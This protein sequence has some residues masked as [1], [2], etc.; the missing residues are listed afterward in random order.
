[1][2]ERKAPNGP[3]G[4]LAS[5]PPR[6][7][8][9]HARHH[10]P[11]AMLADRST[12]VKLDDVSLKLTLSDK[13]L[14]KPFDQAVLSPFLKAYAKRTG[15]KATLDQVS[16]V[17][18]DGVLLGDLS[19]AAS[20]VLL[21]TEAVDTDIFMRHPD[22]RAAPPQPAFEY[23]PFGA[24]SDGPSARAPPGASLKDF[25]EDGRSEVEQLKEARRT[26]RQAREAAEAPAAA[27]AAAAA[28]RPGERVVVCGL[29]SAAGR[30]MNG[31]QGVVVGWVADKQRWEIRLDGGEAHKTVNIKA[32]N[33]ETENPRPL[34][35]APPPAT[36]AT[37]AAPASHSSAAPSSE[38]GTGEAGA[39]QALEA[40]LYASG[41]AGDEALRLEAVGLR[42][43]LAR[44]DE[45]DV[46]AVDE[47]DELSD[48]AA[49]LRGRLAERQAS[50]D[51]IDLSAME[52]VARQAARAMRKLACARL[53]AL[54]PEVQA[55]C[56]EILAARK[57][58]A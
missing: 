43:A 9:R 6:V 34:E 3:Q 18:V 10:R 22:L 14:R 19:I 33:I 1:M 24:A 8:P 31:L 25:D 2:V 15:N 48:R 44:V 29:Q 53:E 32:A 23:S 35:L 20:I 38:V 30:V 26:A 7:A 16:C 41:D 39:A 45:E 58:L 17:K 56:R 36:P 52:D 12:L 5:T 4:E 40:V 54:L 37:P 47:L 21:T 27:A 46:E 49:A 11:L 57:R 28:L 51:Q 13:L 42:A 50:L 55:L